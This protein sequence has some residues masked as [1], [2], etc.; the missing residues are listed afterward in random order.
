MKKIA[1]I[2]SGLTGVSA[3]KALIKRGIKP[4]LLDVGKVLDDKR[5]KIVERLG[6]QD[7][8]DWDPIDLDIITD[9]PTVRNNKIPKKLSFGSDYVYENLH[10][11]LPTDGSPPATFSKGGFST[12]WGG[13]IMPTDDCD[14]TD[15]PIKRKDLEPFY[16]EVLRNLHCSG[17]SDFLERKF[18]TYHSN[19]TPL[20]MSTSIKALFRDILNAGIIDEDKF[21]FGQSRLLTQVLDNADRRG[22]VYCGHC[23]SGCVYKCIYTSGDDLDSLIKGGEID[24]RPKSLVLSLKEYR[25]KVDITIEHSNGVRDISSFDRVFL[26]AGAVNSTRIV[27]ESKQLYN[28]PVFMKTTNG[29]VLPMLRLRAY[30]FDWPNINTEPGLFFE[31]KNKDISDHW[32][33]GQISTPNEF[34][35]KKLNYN[36]LRNNIRD[37]ILKPIFDR[38]NIAHCNMHS[39]HAGSWELS[40]KPSNENQASI[41]VS[42]YR[43]LPESIKFSKKASIQLFKMGMGFKCYG[44]LPS[45][46]PFTDGDTTFHL[47]GSLPMRLFPKFENE[48]DLLG[49]PK[50]WHRIHVVDSSVFPSIPGT[51]VGLPA[52]A[53]AWRIASEVNLN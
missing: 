47:G 51:T 3:A 40:L 17:R 46:T 49:T 52:M 44:I 37:K 34:V 20:N 10:K 8:S 7:K 14:M 32:I 24:Y 48:T 2:G 41:L 33:H 4:V 31:F 25:D 6:H 30:P 45:F 28:Y 1:I 18:P 12:V 16:K 36:P 13:T 35:M 11:S 15:W 23:M 5:Q 38:I 42:R 29:F 9:N 21:L 39:D 53:N 27:L 26:A 43:A 50:G 22:C 19:P